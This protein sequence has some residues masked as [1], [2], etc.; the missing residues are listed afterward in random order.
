MR[1]GDSL[2][3]NLFKVIFPTITR[4]IINLSRFII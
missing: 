1:G 4:E 2:V 3:P